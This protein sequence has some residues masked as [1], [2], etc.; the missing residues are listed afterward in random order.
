MAHFLLISL[1]LI[2]G[3]CPPTNLTGHVSCDT[4]TLTLTWDKNPVSGAAYTVQTERI[5]GALPPS[6]HDTS[7]TSH[8]LTDLECG[9]TYAFRIA[10]QDGNCHSSYSPPV[11]ISTGR[12]RFYGNACKRFTCSS[13]GNY[14]NGKSFFLQSL[15]SQLTSPVTWTVAQTKGI[16]PGLRAVEQVS[17]P[18]RWQ[19]STATWRPVPPATPPALLDSTVAGHTRLHWWLPQKAATAANGPASPLTLVRCTAGTFAKRFDMKRH[20]KTILVCRFFGLKTLLPYQ[21]H[22]INMTFPC[23]YLV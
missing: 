19:G 6:M 5:S 2:P 4:N 18:L 10:A 16:S 20:Y 12:T 22:H 3:L 17:T 15:V 14:H 21:S 23:T 9:Q 1:C 13:K 8:T 11:K 7:D